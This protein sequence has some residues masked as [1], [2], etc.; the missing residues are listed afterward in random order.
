MRMLAGLPSFGR[1]STRAQTD[2]QYIRER[3]LMSTEDDDALAYDGDTP[4]A[5]R[6]RNFAEPDY[7]NMLYARMETA[8]AQVCLPLLSH[9]THGM[10]LAL[11][12]RSRYRV[13][14]DVG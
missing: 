10:V 1:G 5:K 12:M 2:L 4:A 3:A 8:P 13:L 11:D 9:Q 6:S 7:G 14:L